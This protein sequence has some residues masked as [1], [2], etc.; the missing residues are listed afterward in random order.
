MSRVA[1]DDE[2]LGENFDTIYTV[3]GR[4]ALVCHCKS[5]VTGAEDPS[6]LNENF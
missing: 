5:G 6:Q 3:G 2:V 1:L 4:F